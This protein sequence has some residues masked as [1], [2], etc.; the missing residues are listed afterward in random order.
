MTGNRTHASRRLR[1]AQSTRPRSNPT[2]R[3]Q[4]RSTA[5]MTRNLHLIYEALSRARMRLP[6]DTSSEAYR[7]ARQIAMRVRRHESR[8]LGDRI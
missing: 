8:S 6:Q 1:A 5:V 7:S 4:V 3:T 2:N